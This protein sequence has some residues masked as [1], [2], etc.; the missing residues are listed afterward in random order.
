LITTKNIV[1]DHLPIETVVQKQCKK[2]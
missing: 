2:V 1:V